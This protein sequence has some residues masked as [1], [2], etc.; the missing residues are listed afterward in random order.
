MNCSQGWPVPHA[1]VAK[2]NCTRWAPILVINWSYELYN[3]YK[4]PYKLVT[5]DITSPINGLIF[6]Y[7]LGTCGYFTPIFVELFWDP[8]YKS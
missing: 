2:F 6:I 3:P 1:K 8:T 7:K 5:R 4:W